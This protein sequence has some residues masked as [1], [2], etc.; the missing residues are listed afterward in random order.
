MNRRVWAAFNV[1]EAQS[2]AKS[3]GCLSFAQDETRPT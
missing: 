3:G 1:S 2:A